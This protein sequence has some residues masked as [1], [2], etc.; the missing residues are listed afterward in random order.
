MRSH[1][2]VPEIAVQLKDRITN[3]GFVG[4]K[5]KIFDFNMNHTDKGGELFW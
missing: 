2:M 5:V 3:A 1:K 4:Q